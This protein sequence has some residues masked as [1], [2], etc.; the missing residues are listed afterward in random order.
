M[1]IPFTR[2][3]RFFTGLLI[4]GV[5]LFGFG[6]W[7]AAEWALLAI[8]GGHTTGT[9]V[10]KR[11]DPTY[12][13]QKSRSRNAYFVS[14]VFE[15]EGGPQVRSEQFVQVKEY[16]RLTVGTP[17]A[18]DYVRALPGAMNRLAD[19]PTESA[20]D[21]L[22]NTVLTLGTGSLFGTVG[23]RFVLG[24]FLQRR[25]V[26]RLLAVGVRTTGTV[27]DNDA[28]E[29]WI[30]YNLQRR[31]RYSY[32][33]ASGHHWTGLSDWMPRAE[34]ISWHKRTIGIVR[35]DPDRPSD[36]AWFGHEEAAAE[37]APPA[38]T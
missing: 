14:F 24:M 6:I 37:A 9:V 36:S 30:R 27:V 16:D 10:A 38:N 20:T 7:Y 33:D 1:F 34:A 18:V 21:L 17:V 11:I 4:V 5:V 8:D 3:D 13:S 15:P 26:R 32:S 25:L 22:I 19:D 2:P 23:G 31:L 35:Y 12:F 28:A 29:L